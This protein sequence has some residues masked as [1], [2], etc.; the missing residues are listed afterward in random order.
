M[1]KYCR[2][3]VSKGKY[4][5]RR[6]RVR[7]AAVCIGVQREDLG[8]DY[9]TRS[10]TRLGC[11]GDRWSGG[12]AVWSRGTGR[13]RRGGGTGRMAWGEQRRRQ[14]PSRESRA[15]CS[16]MCAHGSCGRRWHLR[17]LNARLSGRQPSP[18]RCALCS[19]RTVACILPC[20]VP[21]LRRLQS[22]DSLA[23]R[24]WGA[25]AWAPRASPAE[26]SAAGSDFFFCYL[27][28]A[29]CLLFPVSCS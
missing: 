7:A 4:V 14:I 13:A 28:N 2:S 27:H 25:V 16:D 9:V 17:T 24:H 22:M 8:R 12:G 18:A 1:C 20:D 3:P 5:P 15:A 23:G 19:T 6:L 10:Q 26:P 11:R 21:Q 29:S